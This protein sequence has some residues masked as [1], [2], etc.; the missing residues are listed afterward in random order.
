MNDM[1][2][3]NLKSAFGGES[4]AHM[5]YLQ[6]GAFATKEGYPNVGN[7]FQAVAY[8]EQVHA[9]NH[10]RELKNEVGEASVTAGAGFGMTTTSE[11]LQGAIDG[12]NYEVEQMYP[13]F[14]AVAELQNEKG[15]MRSFHYAIEAEKTHAEL[16]AKAKEA[17]DSKVDFQEDT[18]HVCDVCGYTLTGALE[19]NCPVCKVKVEMFTTFTTE[20]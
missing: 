5:R 19:D 15:S 9:A 18:V 17:V 12:E 8:A 3:T 7:L 11:N 4:M 16:F 10:F 13:A 14:M 6:W 1:T 2:A 20:K